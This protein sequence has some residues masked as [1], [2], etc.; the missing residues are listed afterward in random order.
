MRLECIT[1]RKGLKFFKVNVSYDPKTKAIHHVFIVDRGRSG[2]DIEK[3]LL[4][5]GIEIGRLIKWIQRR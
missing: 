5:M 3:E 2:Q 1:S 4:N